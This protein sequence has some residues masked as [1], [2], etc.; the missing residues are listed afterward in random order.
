MMLFCGGKKTEQQE[1]RT[2]RHSLSDWLS[3]GGLVKAGESY[4]LGR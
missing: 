3:L 2:P 1:S 4:G